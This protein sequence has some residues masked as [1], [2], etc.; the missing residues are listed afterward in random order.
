MGRKREPT[1]QQTNKQTKKQ[2]KGIGTQLRCI[3][4]LSKS[5]SIWHTLQLVYTFPSSFEPRARFSS[6]IVP[7]RSFFP[8]FKSPN[9]WLVQIK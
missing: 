4:A 2:A 8:P 3:A 7:F 1:V 5:L 9:V 6:L